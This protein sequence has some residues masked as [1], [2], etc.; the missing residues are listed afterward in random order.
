MLIIVAIIGFK[1]LGYKWLK[2]AVIGSIDRT[3][4]ASIGV[5]L[6]AASAGVIQG[7]PTYTGLANTL[8]AKL[9]ELAAENLLILLV[10]TMLISLVLGMGVLTIANYI[11]TSTIVVPAIVMAAPAM[12]AALGID[13]LYLTAYM[14]VFYFGILADVTPPLALAVYAGATLA[15]SHFWKT[16]LN[17]TKCALAGYVIPYI[18][19][20]S[21][22]THRDSIYMDS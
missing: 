10:F 19:T 20:A 11:I 14:F 4:R 12:A 13:A 9:V 17:A 18:C 6:A 7:V 1:A 22:D 5:F 15:R 3:G 8:G 21:R 16:A 2:D